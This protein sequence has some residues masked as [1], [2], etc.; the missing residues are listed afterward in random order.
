MCVFPIGIEDPLMVT[1]D[2]LQHSHLR[3]DHRAAV[4]CRPRFW[5]VTYVKKKRPQRWGFG[6][7]GCAEAV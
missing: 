2:R 1:V 7:L 5:G 6:D 3:E 4:F